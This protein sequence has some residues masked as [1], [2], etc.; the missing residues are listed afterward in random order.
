M[1]EV[2][3]QP[4]R[5]E[6]QREQESL[7]QRILRQESIRDRLKQ[8]N[9]LIA[10][11]DLSARLLVNKKIDQVFDLG[12]EMEITSP[13]IELKKIA[14]RDDA[15]LINGEAQFNLATAIEVCKDLVEEFKTTKVSP[16]TSYFLPL[17]TPTLSSGKDDASERAWFILKKNSSRSIELSLVTE[18]S[19]RRCMDHDCPNYI[20]EEK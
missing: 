14:Y 1:E 17:T 10:T 9:E 15:A 8:W 16:D 20:V 4:N 18:I 7:Q 12:Q 3:P 11:S 13:D 5:T 2:S 6:P 19:A